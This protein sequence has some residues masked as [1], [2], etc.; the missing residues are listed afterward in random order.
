MSNAVDSRVFVL[1]EKSGL[2]FVG[3]D[4][5]APW[6]DDP[7]Q[8]MQ[9]SSA[10]EAWRYAKDL[11]QPQGVFLQGDPVI[12]EALD[13]E[14]GEALRIAP[15]DTPYAL[16][17]SSWRRVLGEPLPLDMP[18]APDSPELARAR[19]ADFLND[20]NWD[21]VRSRGGDSPGFDQSFR[22]AA[23]MLREADPEGF[24]NRLG[25]RSFL[26]SSVLCDSPL[27]R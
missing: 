15:A 24:R 11:E 1:S 18:D 23:D 7:L 21:E 5:P 3:P 6:L 16:L 17:R 13:R 2:F 26:G 20:T 10:S 14:S 22:V 4:A 25:H 27:R 19:L 12:L 9:F 8:A